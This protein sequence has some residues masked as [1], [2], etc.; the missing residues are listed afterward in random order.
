MEKETVKKM[1]SKPMTETSSKKDPIHTNTD[2]KGLADYLKLQ[3][4]NTSQ[5]SNGHIDIFV[6]VRWRP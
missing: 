3:G 4:R 5:Y 2:V 1:T 6:K